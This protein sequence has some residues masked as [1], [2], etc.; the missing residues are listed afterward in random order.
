MKV[1]KKEGIKKVKIVHNKTLLWV[2]LALV[3]FLIMI[4]IALN[5]VQDEKNNSGKI[6]STIN[7]SIRSCNF[8]NDCVPASC[9]HASSCTLK[10]NEPNCA[11]ISCTMDCK[12][13]TLDCGQGSCSC[14]DGKC[15]AVLK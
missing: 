9:C 11:G 5:N 6:N 10:S 7:D 13:N 2:I 1:T 3:I 15:K 12:P 14:I 4:I 8:D